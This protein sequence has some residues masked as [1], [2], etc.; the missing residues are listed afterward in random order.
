MSDAMFLPVAWLLLAVA[1]YQHPG[2]IV[3]LLAAGLIAS[4][5]LRAF[6]LTLARLLVSLFT[7]DLL[8]VVLLSEP[9]T[10]HPNKRAW[11][12]ALIGVG[13]MVATT[14]A[15]KTMRVREFTDSD[16]GHYAWCIG[17]AYLAQIVI[18]GGLFDGLGRWLDNYVR[19]SAPGFHHA[20][21]YVER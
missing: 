3:T 14:I 10:Q 15:Y 13:K 12:I 19:R 5:G 21:F 2:R 6:D 8:V 9:F 17:L 7:I 4:L 1:A 20:L 16:Y 18:A 11:C